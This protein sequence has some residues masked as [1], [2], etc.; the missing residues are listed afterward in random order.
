LRALLFILL[1]PTVML[2]GQQSAKL[3]ALREDLR[4][5]LNIQDQGVS[6]GVSIVSC[7]GTRSSMPDRIFELNAEKLF[8]PAST[9]KLVTSACF[10]DA[11]GDDW[12][13]KTTLFLRGDLQSNGEFIGDIIIRGTG[14]P[15]LSSTFG[16]SPDVLFSH[17]ADLLDSLGIRSIK[18]S[19][20][21]D[22]EYF[23]DDDMYGPGWEW[24]DF[25]YSYATPVSALNVHDNSVT[26]TIIAPTSEADIANVSVDPPTEQLRIVNAIRVLD[27]T[28]TTS[29]RAVREQRSLVTDLVGVVAT[30]APRD[31]VILNL[32]VDNPTTYFLDVFRSALLKKGIR[33]RGSIVDIDDWT[34]TFDRDSLRS[35]AID[36]SPTSTDVIAVINKESANL[37]AEC[38]LRTMAAEPIGDKIHDGSFD[39]GAAFMRRFLD[40]LHYPGA[41]IVDGSGLSRLN[42]LSPTHLT[43]LLRIMDRHASGGV[44]KASLAVPGQ[45]G[46]LRRRMLDSRA[47]KAVRAK[48]G[49]MTHV[50][51][52]AGYVTTRDGEELAFAIM[53]NGLVN[54]PIQV[55]QNIQDLICMR[56]AAFSRY[57]P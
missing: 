48:T 13:W 41:S 40:D 6:V 21:G 16:R 44:Y 15:T 29:I 22:D 37:A 8:I 5:L 38:L 52:L 50:S 14:D 3:D 18:G 33:L 51:S 55:A 12:R 26:V 36:S 9:Q 56:L 7:D 57:V 54:T 32:S 23:V 10:L 53:F 43:T 39:V 34:G 25:P 19:I 1:L 46:T 35:I 49:S 47:T 28:G 31:T 24:D 20:I 4:N 11:L 27:S 30:R 45:A 42:L 2:Q 17:W